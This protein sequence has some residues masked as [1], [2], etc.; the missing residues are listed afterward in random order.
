MRHENLFELA[1][2]NLEKNHFGAV[3]TQRV[4]N[5][6]LKYF[7]IPASLRDLVCASI[8]LHDIGGSSI[9]DQYEKG[10][11]I[12]LR[13]MKQLGY[14]GRLI[15]GICEIIKTHHERLGNPSKAFKILYDADQLAKFSIDEFPFY[16]SKN[17]DWNSIINSM[18][19]ANSKKLARKMLDER[20]KAISI[21]GEVK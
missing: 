21:K 4:L 12:A 5:I 8:I 13:L 7:R 18:Y 14:P 3:H 19:H 15:N 16:N 1:K 6:A 10:P 20:T 11:G 17:T 2:P 9:E